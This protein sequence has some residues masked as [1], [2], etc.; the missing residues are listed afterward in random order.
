MSLWNHLVAMFGTTPAASAP[1]APAVPAEIPL[2]K[3]AISAAAPFADANKWAGPLTLAFRKFEMATPKTMAAILG[4]FAQEAGPGFSEVIENLNYTHADRI[5]SVFPNEFP[6]LASAALCVG[7]P[8]KLANTAYA[9]KLGNGDVLSGDGWTFRGSGLIQLTGRDEYT[10]FAESM[11]GTPEQAAVYCRTVEG[12]AV[13]GVWYF[14]WRKLAPL[15]EAWRL[16]DVTRAVNGRAMLGLQQRIDAA[17]AALAV[18]THTTG[19]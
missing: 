17:N 4:Q 6:T 13:S 8:V 18:F 11:G 14:A 7:N 19:A 3:E 16:S 15:C 9:H 10:A 5:Q 1:V 12:A 2:L